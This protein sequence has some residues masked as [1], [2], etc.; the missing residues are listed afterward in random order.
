MRAPSRSALAALVL[1]L[2]VACGDDDG[3]L[4]PGDDAGLE[5]VFQP[6]FDPLGLEFTYGGVVDYR[7]GKHLQLYVEPAGP[8]TDQQ[9]LDRLVSSSRAIVPFLFDE[10]PELDTFDICQEPVPSGPGDADRPEPRTVVLLS[11]EQAA[12]VADWSTA[13][14][15]DLLRASRV[16]GGGG[17]KVDDAIAALPAYVEADAAAEAPA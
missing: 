12:S 1:I 7:D 9:Y 15:A 14:L 6:F 13:T 11:R 8:A 5:E 10:F 2:P 16:G 17:V 3:G 4:P